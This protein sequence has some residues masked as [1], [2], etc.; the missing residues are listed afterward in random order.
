MKFQECHFCNFTGFEVCLFG[1]FQTFKSGKIHEKSN[2][3][4]PKFVQMIDFEPIHWPILISRKINLGDCRSSKITLFKVPKFMKNQ[5]SE[6]LNVFK[7]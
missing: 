2:F 4:A 1:N 5:I 7:W 3:R 6:P